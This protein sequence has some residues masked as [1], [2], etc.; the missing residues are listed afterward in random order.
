[1]ISRVDKAAN[2]LSVMCKACYIRIAED[3]VNGDGYEKVV[4]GNFKEIMDTIIKRQLDFF[5]KEHLPAPSEIFKDPLT[6][7]RK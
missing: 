4:D 6:R 2:C 3:E 7:K 5:K 1:M